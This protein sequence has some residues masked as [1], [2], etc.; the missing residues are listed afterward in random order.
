[1]RLSNAA[2]KTTTVGEITN[3]MSV[4]AEKMQ[5]AP[6]FFHF[7]WITPITIALTMIFL[8]QKLGPACLVGLAYLFVII[9]ANS[10]LLG[11]FIAKFQVTFHP[12][13]FHWIVKNETEF[14]PSPGS[15]EYFKLILLFTGIES[16]FIRV[17]IGFFSK[18]WIHMCIIIVNMK[19]WQMKYKDLRIKLMNQI[20]TGIKVSY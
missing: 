2:R 7:L 16:S 20:L 18:H 4:D 5:N 17:Y 19:V 14:L 1:M 10:F 3:L 12:G 13:C 15:K 8:W 9:P 6:Q 11:R